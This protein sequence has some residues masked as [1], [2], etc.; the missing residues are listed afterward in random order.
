MSGAAK[1]TDHGGRPG[2]RS[3]TAAVEERAVRRGVVRLSRSGIRSGRLSCWPLW[4]R[5]RPGG[6]CWPTGR[7][8]LRGRRRPTCTCSERLARWWP[9]SSS[10]PW[11]AVGTG[12]ACCGARRRLGVAGVGGWPWPPLGRW[13]CFWS[14]WSWRGWSRASGRRWIGSGPAPSPR[15][16]RSWPTGWPTS[17]STGSARRSAGEATSNRPW[18]SDARCWERPPSSV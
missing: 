16:C 14:P 15:R 4:S 13:R 9:Q 17:C 7:A 8:G 11:V 3:G 12:W 2:A 10:P 6:R 5:G 18:N 1:R